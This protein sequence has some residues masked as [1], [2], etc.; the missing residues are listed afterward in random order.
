MTSF[1]KSPRTKKCK[2]CRASFVPLSA[3]AKACSPDCAKSYVEREQ[4]S[5]A[6]KQ[7]AKE[8]KATKQKLDALRT[9]P[10]LVAMAQKAF[11]A[12]IRARDLGR[13]CI[14]CG[15]PLTS[16]PN[17]YDCGHYRSVGSAVH[18]RFDPTNAHGQCKHCNRHLS[19]NHVMYRL[20]LIERIGLPAVELLEADQTLRKYTKEGLI[21]MA[22]EYRSMVKV[23]IWEKMRRKKCLFIRTQR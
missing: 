23:E 14:S 8:R 21:E 15:K 10:Q 18:L 17:T 4:A 2:V 22:K 16:E 11:N 7:E 3:F 6:R 5:K 20:G 9:K 19:G 12:Y 13:G 1:P